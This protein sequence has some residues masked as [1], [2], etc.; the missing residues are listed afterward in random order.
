M[1]TKFTSFANKSPTNL[2][3]LSFQG[4]G[5]SFTTTI[6]YLGVLL[7]SKLTFRAHIAKM[8]KNIKKYVGIFYHVRQ[9]LPEKCLRVFYFSIIY[10]NLYY[11]VEVSIKPLSLIQSRVSRALQFK[12]WMKNELNTNISTLKGA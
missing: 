7:D 12:N 6:K 9:R 1:W 2:P 4:H 3:I 5:I 10:I 11:C 8:C